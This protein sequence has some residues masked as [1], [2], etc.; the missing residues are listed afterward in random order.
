M[1]ICKTTNKFT[2]TTSTS[3]LQVIFQ[4]ISCLQNKTIFYRKV[5]SEWTLTR[6][7]K[8]NKQSIEGHFKVPQHVEGRV[9]QQDNDERFMGC[10]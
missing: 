2:R 1:K 8:I 7:S 3:L 4:I 9:I 10:V 5:R 6:K